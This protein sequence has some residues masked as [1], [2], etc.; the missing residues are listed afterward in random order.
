MVKGSIWKCIDEDSESYGRYCVIKEIHDNP[1]YNG[2][3]EIELLYSN[4]I[5]HHGKVRRFIPGITHKFVKF[6]KEVK[7][8][9]KKEDKPTSGKALFVKKLLA[10]EEMFNNF[11]DFIVRTADSVV[12]PTDLG[13]PDTN[14]LDSSLDENDSDADIS[15]RTCLMNAYKAYKEAK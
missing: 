8:V 13:L 2:D 9:T 5:R 11:V 15:C 6:S 4:R 3:G 10:D 12:C 14:C 1:E 7:P